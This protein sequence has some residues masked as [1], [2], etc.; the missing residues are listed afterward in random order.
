M[1]FSTPV[2]LIVLICVAPFLITFV[3]SLLIGLAR[4][5]KK[6][7]MEESKDDHC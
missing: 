2:W 3:V 5:K 6:K 4:A 7:K 1:M